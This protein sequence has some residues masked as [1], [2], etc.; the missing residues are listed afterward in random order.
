MLAP[1]ISI[2]APPEKAISWMDGWPAIVSLDKVRV[3]VAGVPPAPAGMSFVN[4]ALAAAVWM[5][6]LTSKDPAAPRLAELICKSVAVSR[7][8]PFVMMKSRLPSSNCRP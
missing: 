7:L 2:W 8:V 1:V 4:S 5:S 3:A 6:M